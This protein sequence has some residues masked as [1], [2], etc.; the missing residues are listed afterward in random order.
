MLQNFYPALRHTDYRITYEIKRFD[1]LNKIREVMRTKPNRL[2][3]REFFLLGNAAEPGSDEF[4]DVYETA[5][6]MYPDDPTANINAANAALQRRD[7]EKADQYLKRAGDSPEAI[8]ARGSLAFLMEDYDK[9]ERLMNEALPSIPEAQST[10]DEI[11]H[12]R[13]NAKTVKKDGTKIFLE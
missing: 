7:F 5:V 4:N 10:L 6:R 3:L 8:Y 11:A 2:S 9:A 13:A 12:I 1:D